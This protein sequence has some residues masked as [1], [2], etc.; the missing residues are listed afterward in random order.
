MSTPS[1]P[2]GGNP[3]GAEAPLL[4][5]IRGRSEAALRSG[6]RPDVTPCHITP[7]SGCEPDTFGDL[8]TE[9]DEVLTDLAA[10]RSLGAAGMVAG[11]QLFVRRAVYAI[12]AATGDRDPRWYAVDRVAIQV[13]RPLPVRL[14][15]KAAT[16]PPPETCS[17]LWHARV[18]VGAAGDLL[19]AAPV[20]PW[21]ASWPTTPPC[22]PLR[23]GGRWPVAGG[24][25]RWPVE[26]SSCRG[27]RVVSP[28]EAEAEPNE[29][30][31]S[32]LRA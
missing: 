15:G 31:F 29:P 28:K 16:P 32:Q 22:E 8:L 5:R 3:R 4:H 18:V 17:R 9:A 25:G 12:T 11:W 2:P 14:R 7:D 21:P 24:R 1:I 6:G 30:E 23:L 26:T 27:S 20:G 10:R 19:A 13:A